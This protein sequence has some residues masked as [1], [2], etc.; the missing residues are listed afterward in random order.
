VR[1]HVEET[2]DVTAENLERILNRC[3]SGGWR[4]DGIQFVVKESARRPSMAFLLFVLPDA[5]ADADAPAERNDPRG[6]RTGA[7][8]GGE[9]ET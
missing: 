9:E 1:Y 3:T 7:P 5:D 6:A 8:A 4:L 2:S